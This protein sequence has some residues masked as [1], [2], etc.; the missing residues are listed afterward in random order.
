MLVEQ[1]SADL[2]RIEQL[3]QRWLIG[4]DNSGISLDQLPE[5]WQ[6]LLEGETPERRALIALALCA[7]QQTLLFEYEATQDLKT[8]PD[9]PQLEFPV[10]SPELRP[11]FRRSLE[12]IR[13]QQ[14]VSINHFLELLLHRKM[15]AHPADWLPSAND[16]VPQVYWPW[17][18]WVSNELTSHHHAEDEAITTENWDDFFPAERLARLTQL[19]RRDSDAARELISQ[20][21]ANEPAEKRLKIIEVLAHNLNQHDAGFL[22]SITQDRSRKIA[23]LATQYLARL[24]IGQERIEG[25]SIE[26]Q[27]KELAEWYEIKSTGLFRKRTVLVP[28]K[29]KSKKQQSI[30]SEQIQNIPLL[31]LSRALGISAEELVSI[32]QFSENRDHDNYAFVSNAANTLADDLIH[33]LLTSAINQLDENQPILAYIQLLLPRLEQEHRNQLML[34]LLQNKASK[35]TFIECLEFVNSPIDE[36]SRELLVSTSAWKMLV[37]EIKQDIAKGVYVEN[38]YTQKE[39]TA[40][41][42]IL[43]QNTAEKIIGELVNLGLLQAD[44]ILDCLKLNM[45]LTGL[46]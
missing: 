14:G 6:P 21:A 26:N 18:Q 19:R 45:Q 33:K 29:L 39:L 8:G 2:Q 10:L 36:L 13:K 34:E 15:V 37:S 38:Y 24:G 23:Q 28:R 17:S 44:P 30:R 31:D 41:G 46:K 42:L 5:G 25:E 35:L 12:V 1:A 9:L 27:A 32:W 22:Q 40:L 11:L 43:P 20:C 4:A 3:H 16:Q 7:Q